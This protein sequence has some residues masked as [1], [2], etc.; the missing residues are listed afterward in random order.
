MRPFEVDALRVGLNDVG[1]HIARDIEDAT[2]VLDGVFVV[3]WS[4]VDAVGGIFVILFAQLHQ[5]LHQRMLKVER[6]LRM[7]CIVVCHNLLF[8]FVCF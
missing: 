3:H 2:V 7:V 6:Y 5:T 8:F 4:I 1:G